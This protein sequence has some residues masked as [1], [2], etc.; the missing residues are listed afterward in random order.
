VTA[1]EMNG[2]RDQLKEIWRLVQQVTVTSPATVSATAAASANTLLTFS[3]FTADGVS[4]VYIEFFS[5]MVDVGNTFQLFFEVF[6]GSSGIG[7]IGAVK[8]GATGSVPV[9]AVTPTFVPSNASHTYSVR[10]WVNSPSVTVNGGAGG[11]AGTQWAMLGRLWS[12][13][14]A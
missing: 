10:A 6:D 8:M 11:A 1:A 5:P 3:A 4:P 7:Q 9:L 2:V 13:G 12:K 14:G